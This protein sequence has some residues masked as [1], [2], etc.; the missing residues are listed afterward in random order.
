M[1][2]DLLAERYKRAKPQTQQD[3]CAFTAREAIA[4]CGPADE[5]FIPTVAETLAAGLFGPAFA[6]GTPEQRR[7]WVDMMESAYRKAI[8]TFQAI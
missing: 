1:I 8:W 4:V 5:D 7:A 2:V 6:N 3:L